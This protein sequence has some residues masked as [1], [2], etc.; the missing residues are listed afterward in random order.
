M[1]AGAQRLGHRSEKEPEGDWRP[2]LCNRGRIY[3]RYVQ[4]FR[5]RGKDDRADVK[6]NGVYLSEKEKKI[7]TD[8]TLVWN[9]GP[10]K[11]K[12][13]GLQEMARRKAEMHKQGMYDRL[14]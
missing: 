5:I 14:R 3:A 12:A 4:K 11:G 13:L 2:K 6:R 8:G 7:A 10:N 9:Y 1:D